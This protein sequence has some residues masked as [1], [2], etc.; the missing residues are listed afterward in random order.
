MEKIGYNLLAAVHNL[1]LVARAETLVNNFLSDDDG[2]I[3]VQN[4]DGTT[5]KLQTGVKFIATTGLGI[6]IDK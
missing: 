2:F 4:P 6:T 1:D 3:Y 5:F